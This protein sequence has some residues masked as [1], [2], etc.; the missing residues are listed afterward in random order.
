MERKLIV[1]KAVWSGLYQDAWEEP[2]LLGHFYTR[3]LALE[4]IECYKENTPSEELLYEDG[5][6]YD[7][8]RI[9]DIEVSF[10]L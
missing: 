9:V 6:A 1:F 2:Y 8:S 10:S 3:E 5:S 7:G 4:A